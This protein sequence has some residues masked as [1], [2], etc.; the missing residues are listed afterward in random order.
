MRGVG[1]RRHRL[2]GQ[3]LISEAHVQW[4]KPSRSD[5][6]CKK[7]FAAE[8]PQ[9]QQSP[10]LLSDLAMPFGYMTPAQEQPTRAQGEKSSSSS[11]AASSAA[12]AHTLNK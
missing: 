9:E 10:N 4:W 12:G 5:S 11:M 2:R 6:S 1:P 7:L 8:R 3:V